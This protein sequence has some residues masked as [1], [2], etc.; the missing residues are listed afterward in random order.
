MLRHALRYCKYEPTI[1]RAHHLRTTPGC[2]VARG[3][4][5]GYSTKTAVSGKLRLWPKRSPISAPPMPR[6]PADQ[7]FGGVFFL[8]DGRPPNR[9]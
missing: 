3:L 7:G 5:V 2:I 9:R 6:I 4:Q 1:F 8:A